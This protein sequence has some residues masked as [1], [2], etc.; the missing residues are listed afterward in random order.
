MR[1]LLAAAAL[2]SACSAV[3]PAALSALSG[4]D[5]LTSDVADLSVTVERDATLALRPGASLRLSAAA[6]GGTS[7][8]ETFVLERRQARRPAPGG[9]TLLRDT[10]RLAG[11]DAARFEA[12]QQR[13]TALKAAQG[14]GVEGSF[15]V[16]ASA[17]ATGPLPEGPLPVSTY[18]QTAPDGPLVPVVRDV[19]L[20]A[21]ARQGT[22]VPD[23]GPCP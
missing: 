5:P 4:F 22:G 17:C 13:I 19:D 15:S 21:L 8:D 23:I 6:P 9:G 16:S 10:F 20:R 2:L 18:L 7:L 12:L 14:D 3:D 11:S 1:S